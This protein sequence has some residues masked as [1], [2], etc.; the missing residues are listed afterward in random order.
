MST[1]L[2][3]G[4][5]SSSFGERYDAKIVDMLEH[6]RSIGEGLVGFGEL[7]PGLTL[8]RQT[9]KC[10]IAPGIEPD[11]DDSAKTSIILSLLGRSGFASQIVEHFDSLHCLKTYKSERNPSV[12]A[13]CNALLS[14][15]LDSDSARPQYAAIQKMIQFICEKWR[16]ASGSLDDKWVQSP[17]P[18]ER[19][20]RAN[21]EMR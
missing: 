11:L 6:S 21:E 3:S 9:A 12:S 14:V 17:R 8:L 5:W 19:A 20:A 16:N 10:S 13:N 7:S 2:E 1:L 15:L 4:L 18:I